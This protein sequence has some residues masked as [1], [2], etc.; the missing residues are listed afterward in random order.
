MT[1]YAL[2]SA[3]FL[4]AAPA[5]AQ[6]EQP[7]GATAPP[8]A[9]VT[10]TAQPAEDPSGLAQARQ[11]VA[12]C[13]GERF[14]F[15]WGAGAN[16]TKVTL[17]SE[18]GATPEQ[19]AAML[20]EAAAKIE[21]T[22]SIPEDRRIALVQ[23]IR[24][25]AVEVRRTADASASQATAATAATVANPPP[26]AAARL[27][28]AEISAL[29]P[30]PAPVRQQPVASAARPL[31]PP[32]RIDF[33]CITPGELGAGG[34]CVTLN[35]DTILIVQSRDAV[36]EPLALRFVRDGQVR[37]EVAVG[38]MRKGQARRLGLPRQVC[39]GVSTAE[40]RIRVVR[41]GQDVKT[42][43]PYLLRC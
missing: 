6:D 18:K 26:T 34:P 30:L 37:G 1:R 11:K 43:G 39:S 29:P 8:P 7:S 21:K 28:A 17:C 23:Q 42:A 15:A 35:R 33:E 5:F 14:V 4:L 3:L 9:P 40:V 2:I 10:E 25:R 19:V 13:E 31:L 20:E 22:A 38:A 12:N 32:A 36:P 41:A 27:P 16:P 24:A